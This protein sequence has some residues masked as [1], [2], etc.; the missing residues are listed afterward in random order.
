M[1]FAAWLQ[2]QVYRL[3]GGGTI[4]LPAGTYDLDGC[5]KVPAGVTGLTIQGAGDGLTILRQSSRAGNISPIFYFEGVDNCTLQDLTIEASSGDPNI[6]VLFNASSTVTAQRMTITGGQTACIEFRTCNGVVAS[7]LIVGNLGNVGPGKGRGV[8][9]TTS[10]QNVVATT[11]RAFDANI[12]HMTCCEDNV[13]N[14]VMTDIRTEIAHTFAA[15]D[16]HGKLEGN[17]SVGSITINNSAGLV[18]VGNDTHL[19]GSHATVTNHDGQGKAIEVLSNS[20]LRY[21]NV[22]NATITLFANGTAINM[23]APSES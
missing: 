3:A 11:I 9:F 21:E 23:G 8:Y 17:A 19:S 22:T 4:T 14:V 1:R 2:C 20:V 18:R 6:P 7:N 13:E 5:I 12:R 10:T 16:L 15:V